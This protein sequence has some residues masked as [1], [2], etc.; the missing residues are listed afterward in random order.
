MK[1]DEENLKDSTHTKLG[2]TTVTIE[3]DPTIEKLLCNKRK[4]AVTS[5][6]D[7][8]MCSYWQ[9]HLALAV[10]VVMWNLQCW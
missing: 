7:L 3:L 8:I 9:V 10:I 1:M 2:D 6:H 4:E 5:E